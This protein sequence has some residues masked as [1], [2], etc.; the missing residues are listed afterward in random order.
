LKDTT[1]KRDYKKK[2]INN[3]NSILDTINNEIKELIIK[4]K[5]STDKHDRNYFKEIDNT[6]RKFSLFNYQLRLIALRRKL[7]LSA[8]KERVFLDLLLP[9]DESSK[10]LENCLEFF[11]KQRMSN[12]DILIRLS[13]DYTWLFIKRAS[14]FL[15]MIDYEDLF[16]YFLNMGKK[17]P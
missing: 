5:E 1:Q 2:I 7:E 17:L 15:Q 13:T 4:I 6:K 9:I 10:E 3:K 8:V 11:S 14:N 12:A 16:Y